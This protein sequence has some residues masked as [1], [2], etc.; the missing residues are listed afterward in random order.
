[1]SER[2][3]L[4]TPGTA[5]MTNATAKTYLKIDTS[6]DD[7]LIASL[8]TTATDAGER[9][10]SKEFRNNQYYLYLDTLDA[11]ICLR[12]SPVI[13]VEDVEY[14]V[15][16]SLTSIP[17]SVWYLKQGFPWSEILLKDGQSWP[18]DG[19]ILEGGVRVSFTAGPHPSS[20]I[21]ENGVKRHV[22]YLYENRG[23]CGDLSH[24][25]LIKI[26]GAAM[27]YDRIRTPRI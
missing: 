1:M 11:R 24:A 8:I 15:S 3:E 14:T 13:S 26:S 7:A 9:Y 22:A 25:D 17:T 5:V 27:G 23:D 6:A 19:D 21:I 18:I 16:G 4:A 12:R 10:T 20:D 2:Y